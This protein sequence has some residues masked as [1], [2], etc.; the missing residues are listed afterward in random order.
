MIAARKPR[1]PE[2]ERAAEKEK[3]RAAG[4]VHARSAEIRGLRGLFAVKASQP[5]PRDGSTLKRTST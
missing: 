5:E 3:A 2:F 1:W 4:E